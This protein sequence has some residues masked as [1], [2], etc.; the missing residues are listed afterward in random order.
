MKVPGGRWGCEGRPPRPPP[1]PSLLALLLLLCL[2]AS[3][4][5]GPAAACGPGRGAGKRPRPR[6]LTPLVFKQ[7]VPN[8]SE[9]TLGASGLAEGRIARSDARFRDLEP[10]YNADIVFKDEEGTG[11]D[12]LMTQVSV[13]RG[14]LPFT[15]AKCP[16]CFYGNA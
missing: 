12:R 1:P 3:L 11:E 16:Q 2:A 5:V 10:N 8:V 9:H 7:H 14:D 13:P 4:A 6:K 15:L